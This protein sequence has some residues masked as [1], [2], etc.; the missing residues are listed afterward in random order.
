M[1]KKS[2][3]QITPDNFLDSYKPVSPR[4]KGDGGAAEEQ[5]ELPKVEMQKE[6]SGVSENV[7]LQSRQNA[8]AMSRQEYQRIFL[9]PNFGESM[10]YGKT[11]YVSKDDCKKIKALMRCFGESYDRF[12]M[13]VFIHNLL[14]DHF[15]RFSNFIDEMMSRQSNSNP[16]NTSDE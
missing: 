4:R 6:R 8:V 10:R 16:F 9:C 7:V 15:T 5:T 14:A 11:Y 1:P 3:A 2:D 13:S 12:P